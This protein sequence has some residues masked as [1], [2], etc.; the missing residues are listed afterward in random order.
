[1]AGTAWLAAGL[2]GVVLLAGLVFLLLYDWPALGGTVGAMMGAFTFVLGLLGLREDK[3]F[4]QR[5]S[6]FLGKSHPAQAV[7]A[8]VLA[9]G[10]ILW[11]IVGRPKMVEVVCG[12]LGCRPAG[13]QR[14]AIGEFKNLTP[15]RTELDDVWT[16]GTREMLIQKLGQVPSLQLINEASPQTTEKVKRDLDYWIEGQ[17][18]V[19]DRAELRSRLSRR[20]GEYLS[21]DVRV[22]GEATETLANITSLQ[23]ALALAL[24]P[25]LGI[26]PEPAL[27]ETLR[28]TPTGDVEA[29]ALNNE[30]V[31]LIRA[32]DY[33]AAESKFR[34]ALSLDPGFS[35]AH[36]NLGFA[37]AEQGDYDGAIVSYQAAIEHLPYYAVFRYNLG[38]L[39]LR[40]G[41]TEGALLSLQEAV[42]LDPG[43]VH[44]YN[45]LGNVY[46]LREQWADA[47]EAL[48]KGLA[49]DP[50]FAPLHKNLA[51]VALAQGKT[52][53]AIDLLGTALQ[54]YQEKPLEATYLLAMAY[55]QAGQ[56][57]KA[58]QQLAA[59]WVLDPNRISEWALDAEDLENQL[60]CP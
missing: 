32:Q 34:A 4:F 38:N 15:D 27:A 53:E 45:E 39:Y 60:G 35:V 33:P 12:P 14:L 18:Q 51:R 28:N 17:F 55:A 7:M 1:V 5:L 8:G 13:V 57:A 11:V 46:I 37:L 50:S 29:L 19:V 42:R 47:R 41:R 26:E 10:I 3:D 22:E 44:A 54:L 30:G 6:H 25:R 59:Y 20:G 24:L 23:N 9:A 48:E 16:E 36:A 21:P 43:Y 52:K 2:L 58:C 56:E 40:L 31:E 49:L